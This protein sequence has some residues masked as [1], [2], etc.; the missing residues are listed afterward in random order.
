MHQV[1]KFIKRFKMNHPVEM[2]ECFLNGDCYYFALILKNRF[3]EAT[4]K[5]M[6]IDNHFIVEIDGELYDIRGNVSNICNV[7]DLINW[8]DLE[9]YDNLLYERIVRDCIRFEEGD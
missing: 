9:K 7:P 5:Y 8:D 2:E 4:I 6:I 1:D 3:P